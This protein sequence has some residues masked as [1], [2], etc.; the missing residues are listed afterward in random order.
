MRVGKWVFKE[1]HEEENLSSRIFAGVRLGVRPTR[2]LCSMVLG[3]SSVTL[4]LFVQCG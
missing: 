3:T 2:G 1:A 4:P